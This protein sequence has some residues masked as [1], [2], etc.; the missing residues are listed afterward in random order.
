MEIDE[1]YIFVDVISGFKRGEIRVQYKAM[2]DE[3]EQG[4]IKTILFSEL[5]RLGRNAT[6]LLEQ[7]KYLQERNVSLYFDK[8]KLW[9]N[10]A[11]TKG[12]GNIILLHILAIMSSYEI[13]L[14]AERTLSGK[15][16]KVQAGH[17]GGEERAYGYMHNGRKEIVICEEEAE[18]VREIFEKYVAGASSLEIRD[19]LVGK[20]VA[21][22]YCRKI[23]EFKENRKNRGQTE[24]NY[25]INADSLVWRTS[26]IN[27]L[28][29][30]ELYTG[31]RH[32]V[33]RKPDP[34][35]PVPA[36][37]RK[38]REII[39]EH[40]LQDERL[41]IV[42]D[43]LF[44]QAQDKLL[45]ANYN[46]NNAIRHENLLKHLMRCGECGC[47]FSVGKNERKEISL[48]NGG[49]TYR[50]YGAVSR[51]DKA[52]ICKEGVELRMWKVDGLV[53]QLSLMTFADSDW[54]RRCKEQF[55]KLTEEIDILKNA[56]MTEESKLRKEEE[57]NEQIL[58]RLLRWSGQRANINVD[59]LYDEECARYENVC[60]EMQRTLERM[61]IELSKK[62]IL[63]DSLE[64][65]R[66]DAVLY[67]HMNDIQNDK[68]LIKF[69]VN[70]YIE[71][72][73]VYRPCKSWCLIEIKYKSGGSVWGTLKTHRYR[74]SEM[75]CDPATTFHGVE[76]QTW[77]V[78]NW[79]NAFFYDP[80]LKL[81]H[82]NGKSKYIE[83]VEEGDYT[84]EEFDLKIKELEMMGSFPLYDYEN[85][86]F[87]SACKLE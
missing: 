70:E 82:C 31:K 38:E 84:F 26:T 45:R 28:L 57:R 55:K 52:K 83:Q 33:Y 78:P 58:R 6:E 27:R 81:I 32:V 87:V 69:L 61:R 39:Y 22:P 49:R 3:I 62:N 75:F 56:I 14:F 18:V 85:D 8:E 65:M 12:L 34:T 11:E 79:D 63:R 2:L 44:L 16:A 72:I 42:S 46:K 66:N 47:N 48:K 35:N 37:K 80:K 67:K 41:R 29:H 40:V 19:W 4:H 25:K 54:E 9:V 68:K 21:S 7:V 17:G 53:L 20:G 77:V 51:R 5:S 30:N 73:N 86:R 64:K 59:K 76:L 43:E 10:E 24:K 15:I 74:K 71:I 23:K 1:E 36:K 60:D 50:C 13:E